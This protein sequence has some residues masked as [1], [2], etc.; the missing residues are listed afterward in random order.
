MKIFHE[1]RFRIPSA[2]ENRLGVW[3]DR[4]GSDSRREDPAPRRLRILGQYAAVA[5]ETGSGRLFM[6]GKAVMSLRAGDVI[7]LSPRQPA[8]YH[9][10]PVWTS[11]WVVWNGA[12]MSLWEKSGLACFKHPVIHGGDAVVT[13]AFRRLDELLRLEDGTAAVERK[14]VL[15]EMALG[16]SRLAGG[17][18]AGR[19]DD[20]AARVAA[21]MEERFQ[22]QLSVENLARR[23]HAS[24]SQL[25]RLFKA[26][27]GW[28]PNEY[29]NVIRVTKAKELLS[30]GMTIKE[31]AAQTGFDDCFYFMRVFKRVAGVTAGCFRRH[32][33]GMA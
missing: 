3:V 19:G 23:F 17:K 13:R 28:T 11:R 24:S 25:R 10:S 6:Q 30:Q 26:R 22:E 27:I 21:F 5:I 4:I 12:E 29:A 1:T 32:V 8:A 2:M 7:M 18:N 33:R 16:L 31:A 15:M 9:A 20:L 14:S